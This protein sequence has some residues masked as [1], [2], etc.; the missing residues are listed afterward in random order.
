[1]PPTVRRAV[2]LLT[3][4]LLAVA[5][6]TVAV[7]APAGAAVTRV[8]TTVDIRCAFTT[9][10]QSADW[11]FPTGQPQGLIWLQHGFARANDHVR[12]LAGKYAGAGY[13]V[14]SPTLPS[15]HLL[16]C[17]LQNIG[18]NTDFLNNVADLFG[19]ASDPA[20]KLGRSLAAA[21]SQ[22]GRPEV[23]MPSRMLFSG[24]SAGGEA[25]LYVADRVRS[26]YPGAWS[27]LRGL[28]L[29]DPVKSF[30]GDNTDASLG[31]LAGTALPIL[32]VSAPNSTC[33]NSGS[34]TAAVQSILRKPFVGVRITSG[35]HTDAEGASTDSVGTIA[36]GT[37][38]AANVAILQTL[39]VGWAR[40]GFNGTRTPD[41]YP[42]G[43][44]YQ[45]QLSGG[46][47][48]T[49]AGASS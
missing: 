26:T 8:Q 40:D 46:K 27:G 35:V 15:A 43:A 44:Y 2:R 32:T 14:F 12:D 5:P 20:D 48:Q 42:G 13:L 31:R 34:G 25:A 45:G 11:Y 39:A 38:Q 49:L 7:P 29:L 17:T 10:K 41:Y 37:P 23:T 3:A 22:A 19:K 16:G 1:M 24:H 28:V 21:R 30:I 4:A 9:L 47:I 33:N 6:L 18:N 36:C